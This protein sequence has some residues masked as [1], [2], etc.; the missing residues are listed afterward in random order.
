MRL[1]PIGTCALLVFGV[2]ARLSAQDVTPP[3]LVDLTFD[4][5]AFDVSHGDATATL[6]WHIQDDLSGVRQL[7]AQWNSPSDGQVAVL[8]GFNSTLVSGT[9][10]DGIWQIEMTLPQLSEFGIWT[11]RVVQIWDNANN[12]ALHSVGDPLF[13]ELSINLTVVPEPSSIALAA[14][15][16]AGPGVWL[17]RRFRSR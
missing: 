8:T 16:L 15:G 14:I 10:N 13:T 6:A 12:L 2:H 1:V 3:T 4:P 5:P 11:P 17:L 7:Q 9:I